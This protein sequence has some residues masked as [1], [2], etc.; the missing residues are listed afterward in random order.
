MTKAKAK[1]INHKERSDPDEVLRGLTSEDCQTDKKG[2]EDSSQEESELGL[3]EDE[4]TR[5]QQQEYNYEQH[6]VNERLTSEDTAFVIETMKKEA[7]HDEVSIKQLFYGYTSAFTKCPILHTINSRDSGAGKTYL[8]VTVAG[9]FPSKYVIE[10]AGMSDKALVHRPGIMVIS[11]YNEETDEEETH[12][13]DP[14]I[15]ELELQI[16]EIES[17]EKLSKEDKEKIKTIKIEIKDLESRAE[18]LID[19]NNQI[20]LCLDTPQNSLL[21]VLMSLTSQDTPRD[22]KYTF[23]EKSASGQLRTRVNRLRGMP[24]LFAT[25]VIDDT[26]ALRFQE[27]NKNNTTANITD[28][29]LHR[30]LQEKSA[31]IPILGQLEEPNKTDIIT[32]SFMYSCYYCK[33]CQTNQKDEYE[34]HVVMKHPGKVAY[35]GLADLI[36][37]GI[38]PQGRSW[39]TMDS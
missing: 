23:A 18:K 4:D 37:L 8:L 24:V 32:G 26:R 22:Q 16:E 7:V 21:N 2:H 11:E 29:S 28:D 19:L 36:R 31:E 17:K 15:T 9:Y 25:R 30:E 10:L 6:L 39:E 34:H 14:I 33:G 38:Q 35:P 27:K 5:N 1:I 3:S 13:I 20:I 12:P